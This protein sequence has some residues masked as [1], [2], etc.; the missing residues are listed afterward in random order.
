MPVL[1]QTS[2]P[3]ILLL[4]CAAHSESLDGRHFTVRHS[5]IPAISAFVAVPTVMSLN[6]RD[7]S[8][9]QM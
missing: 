6:G 7:G 3:A 1:L 2:M 9:D 4:S 5:S 8:L